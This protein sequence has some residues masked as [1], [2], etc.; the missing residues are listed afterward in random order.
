MDDI[1]TPIKFY[2]V[3]P[4]LLL[5]LTHGLLADVHTVLATTQYILPHS[6][7]RWRPVYTSSLA[8]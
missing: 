5:K 6:S 3:I 8:P 1:I 7:P 2:E 4:N